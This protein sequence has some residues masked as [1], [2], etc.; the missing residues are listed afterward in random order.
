MF[1]GKCVIECPE[2]YYIDQGVCEKAGGNTG[3]CAEGCTNAKLYN[4][5][6]DSECNFQACDFDRGMCL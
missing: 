4:A 2:G 3:E 6:C 1:D 5:V